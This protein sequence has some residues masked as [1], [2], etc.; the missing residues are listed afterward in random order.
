M[1][2]SSSRDRLLDVIKLSG[3][4]KMEFAEKIG[5]SAGAISHITSS[6][7]KGRKADISE[8]VANK[9]IATFPS[10]HLRYD[11]LM[12]G[13]G[14]MTDFETSGHIQPSLF[15]MNLQEATSLNVQSE[16]KSPQSAMIDNLSD[17]EPMTVQIARP[18]K[19]ENRQSPYQGETGNTSYPA[20]EINSTKSQPVGDVNGRLAYANEQLNDFQKGAN[21][22]GTPKLERIVMFYS[23]GTFVEYKPQKK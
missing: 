1:E 18:D 9:I 10:L 21:R 17:G 4:S 12:H 19:A 13:N 3:L 6:S 16:N 7:D 5:V 15:D 2:N 22:E 11:W 23:D 14:A 8:N 20:Y